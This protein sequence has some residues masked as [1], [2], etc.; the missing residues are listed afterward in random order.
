MCH[1]QTENFLPEATNMNLMQMLQITKVIRNHK[2]EF[3]TIHQ[4]D[5][6]DILQV[7]MERDKIRQRGNSGVV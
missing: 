5:F 2:L 3:Y 7:K 4:F 6:W 1:C